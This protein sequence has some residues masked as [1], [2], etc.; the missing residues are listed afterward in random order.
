[1][2]FIDFLFSL[3]NWC[4]A[5]IPAAFVTLV[6]GRRTSRSSFGR[7]HDERDSF[8][9]GISLSR[10]LSQRHP[11]LSLSR[12]LSP[13]HSLPRHETR[14]RHSNTS[15]HCK[16]PSFALINHSNLP[17]ITGMHF[18]IRNYPQTP[19]TLPQTTHLKRLLHSIITTDPRKIA[20][21][22]RPT[23]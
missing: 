15:M 17:E 13:S 3:Q 14:F 20:V 21:Y 6:N 5:R 22:V 1:M 8:V 11:L 4:Q 2:K 19:R 16:S 9:S 10:S 7:T 12:T 23:F 18:R